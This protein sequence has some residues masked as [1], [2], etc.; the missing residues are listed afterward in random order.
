MAEDVVGDLE[1]DPRTVVARDARLLGQLVADI[2]ED[3][4]TQIVRVHVDVV[5]L[6]PE[7][8]DDREV[9]AALDLGERIL[10]R[11]DRRGRV[12]ALVQVHQRLRPIRVRPPEADELSA[13]W[14]VEVF[15]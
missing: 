3:P 13:G 10:V 11:R 9:D 15:A 14:A 5:D 6:R 12:E 1:R 7:I 4:F 2:G 8:P